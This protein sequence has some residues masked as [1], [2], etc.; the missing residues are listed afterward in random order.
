MISVA[1]SATT[2]TTTVGEIVAWIIGW[3]L[4]RKC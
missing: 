1:S 4:I 3:D 2:F